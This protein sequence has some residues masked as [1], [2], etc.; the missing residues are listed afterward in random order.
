MIQHKIFPALML[1]ASAIGFTACDDDPALPPM[2]VPEATIEANTSILELKEQFWNSDASV[3]NY[4][5]TIGTLAD[6]RHMIIKGRVVGN[7]ISGNISKY[8]TI[9]DETA[10]ISFSIDAYDLY[11]QYHIGQEVVVDMTDMYIG[12]YN[13]QYLVGYPGFYADQNVWQAGRM[14]LEL[15]QEHAQVNGL[16][17]MTAV[18]TATVTIPQVKA[19]APSNS[20]DM[21][22]W[23]HRLVKFENV[24]FQDAGKETFAPYHVNNVVRNIVDAN[25][26]TFPTINSGYA[27]FYDKAVPTGTGTVT[28]ILSYV[29]RDGWRLTIREYSDVI[30]FDSNTIVEK[31]ELPTDGGTLE[32]PYTIA[33]VIAMAPTSKDTPAEGQGNVWIE[34][35][36]VGWADLGTGHTVI[37]AETAKFDAAATLATNLLV[38]A[39]ADETDVTKCI[40]VQ[41]PNNAVRPV[42]NL[43]ENPDNY[44]KPVKLR[45]DV[46]QYSGVTGLKNTSAYVLDGVQGPAEPEQPEGDLIY[47]GLSED[48]TSIDWTFDNVLLPESVKEIW[49]WKSYSNKYYLNGSAFGSTLAASEAYAISPVIDLTG[50]TSA[51]VAFDHAAKFQTTIK[52]LC[53]LVVREAGSSDWSTLKIETWPPL[54]NKWTWVNSGAIDLSAFAGKKIEIAF[55]YGSST[56]GADTWEIKNVKVTGK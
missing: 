45:G 41:L 42:L 7:D 27:D 48:A 8:L 31:P 9:Q 54:D 13:R 10:A 19:I 20:A 47:S 46:L 28:G 33:E 35:Y 11:K 43:K 22:K 32:K 50:K 44:K 15:M 40:G 30:G 24:T 53:G 25:G 4:I 12:K 18:D 14:T 16:I 38:A 3:Y 56:A 34:G 55:K 6:G 36:I 2:I 21:V 37:N 5:D 52:E 29:G 17:D 51:N 1:A 39:S 49:T 23:G 26:N